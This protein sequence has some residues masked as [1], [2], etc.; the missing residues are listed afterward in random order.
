LI[1]ASTFRNAKANGTDIEIRLIMDI[2]KLALKPKI[3]RINKLKWTKT[4]IILMIAKL[5]VV[6]K[7]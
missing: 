4:E 2:A 6:K 5:K 1:N 3:N 7:V